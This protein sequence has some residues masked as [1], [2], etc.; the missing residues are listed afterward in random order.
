MAER[1]VLSARSW[2]GGIRVQD[3]GT[4]T[5]CDT[6]GGLVVEHQNQPTLRMMG[7]RLGLA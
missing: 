3:V 1:A 6:Y 5:Q 7:F 2:T 4:R